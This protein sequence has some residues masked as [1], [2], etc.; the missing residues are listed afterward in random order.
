MKVAIYARYSTDLQDKTSIA[1]QITNCEAL[2]AQEGFDV[3]TRYQDAARSGNDDN[4]PQY[5]QLF[6]DAEAG[7]FDAIIVDETSRLTRRPGELP[8]CWK[9]SHSATSFS[10]IAAASTADRKRQDF[11]RAYTAVLTASKFARSKGARTGVCGSDTKPDFQPVAELTDIRAR[12]LTQPTWVP[13][14]GKSSTRT[15]PS[16]SCG[17]SSGMPRVWA[18]SES[19][20]N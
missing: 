4:R 14:G 2:A 15:K 20:P 11:W 18:A 3:V 19:L 8:A 12:L 17:F 1:G 16:G 9:F 6:A 5:Q 7:L 10:S 13:S